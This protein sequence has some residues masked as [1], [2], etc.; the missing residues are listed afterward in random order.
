MSLQGT[1]YCG[2]MAE[3]SGSVVAFVSAVDETNQYTLGKLHLFN[4]L[5][6]REEMSGN[7]TAP[8]SL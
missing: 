8:N 1:T 7:F 4:A 2:S 6:S 3:R 5:P